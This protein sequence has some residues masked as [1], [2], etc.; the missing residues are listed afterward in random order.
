[1][2]ER[3]TES[4]AGWYSKADELF[5]MIWMMKGRNEIELMSFLA[6]LAQALHFS[7]K[8]NIDM[9]TGLRA[10]YLKLEEIDR[11]L[12]RIETGRQR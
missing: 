8:G 7:S 10:T 1:M 6:G 12:A 9:A 4:A 3:P 5:K 2:S 11:R